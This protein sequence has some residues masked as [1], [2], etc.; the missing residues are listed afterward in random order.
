[1]LSRLWFGN[2]RGYKA[3]ELTTLGAEEQRRVHHVLQ[4]FYALAAS[5]V[6]FRA[7][8]KKAAAGREAMAERTM[9]QRT[10]TREAAGDQELA[11]ILIELAE[12]LGPHPADEAVFY[13][14][15]VA[16][17][18]APARPAIA[19][20]PPSDKA[21]A[22]ASPKSP[23]PEPSPASSPAGARARR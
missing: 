10:L 8:S 16:A 17:L 3:Q 21:E 14:T 19:L 9:L 20:T 18:G 23:S 4:R 13:Q 6:R 7:L 11:Q 15:I 22:P 5:T 1:V 2:E 12:R